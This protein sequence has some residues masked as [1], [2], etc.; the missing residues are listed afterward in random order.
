M[1]RYLIELQLP[2]DDKADFARLGRVVRAALKRMDD[3][4]AESSVNSIG[5]V[6][7]GHRTYCVVQAT[8]A[9]SVTKL[10][11]TAMVPSRILRITEL[12]LRRG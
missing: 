5:L 6:S 8:S 4:R 9:E 7:N 3:G 12:G 1:P 2:S 10:M 11:Q